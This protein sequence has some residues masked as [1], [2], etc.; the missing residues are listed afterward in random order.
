MK[1]IT[2]R[3][4]VPGDAAAISM[5][6]ARSW[7][8]AYAG[9]VPQDYLDSL[10]DGHSA[11]RV[12]K[13]LAS[14][15]LNAFLLREGVTPAGAV[16]FAPSRDESRAGWGEIQFLYVR[17][18]F[19]RRGY[20]KKLLFAA[21]D[22]LGRLGFETCFLWVLEQNRNAR[23]FYSAAGFRQTRDVMHSEILGQTLTELR[24][25]FPAEAE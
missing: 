11:K 12:E 10:G 4:A 22:A 23:D 20:G 16:G 18:G 14:G 13:E 6:L 25:V 2:V 8:A 7:K 17:P 19:C 9:M 3:R 5:I 1:D 24:Y 15:T 21:V